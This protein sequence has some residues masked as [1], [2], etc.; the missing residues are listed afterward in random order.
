MESGTTHTVAAR[1]AIAGGVRRVWQRRRERASLVVYACNEA[2]AAFEAVEAWLA[3]EGE[4]EEE[5]ARVQ[6]VVDAVALLKRVVE[7]NG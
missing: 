2:L 1:E 4:P 5:E 6:R 3:G 7:E